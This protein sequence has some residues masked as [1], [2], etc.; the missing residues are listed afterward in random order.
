M[1]KHAAKNLPYLLRYVADHY[2][3]QNMCDKAIPENDE[4]FKSVSDCYRSQEMCSKSVN[5]CPQ[6]SKFVPD[7]LKNMFD[8]AVNI[9]ISTTKFVPKC[10]EIQQMCNLAVNRC[11]F[12][13]D[14][15][16]DWYKAQEMC[17]RVVPEDSYLKVS[18]PDS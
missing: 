17:D 8:K 13:F 3:T 4:T 5:N 18:F 16:L 6:A 7:C 15:I 14:S 10:Y 12:V 2:K 1:Y 11:F 9:Y